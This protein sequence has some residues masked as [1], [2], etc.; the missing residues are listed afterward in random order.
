MREEEFHSLLEAVMAETLK[1]DALKNAEV[2]QERFAVL[3][4]LCD[5]FSEVL[6]N[7]DSE[8]RIALHPSFRTGSVEV[9]VDEL[10]L[11]REEV[12]RFREILGLAGTLSI[13]PLTNGT[14]S[15]AATVS[16]VF[17]S[18]DD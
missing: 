6:G 17:K 3:K 5:G 15:V 4:T 13:E 16:K 18:K 2:D 12:Q 10:H 7:G 8:A 9:R 1:E 11:N 14:V